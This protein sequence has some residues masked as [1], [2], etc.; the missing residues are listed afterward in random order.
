MRQIE[1][2]NEPGGPLAAR[3]GSLKLWAT[4][5]A[6]I[7]LKKVH[8]KGS[9][10]APITIVE[11]SDL[12]CSHCKQAHDTLSKELFKA[13]KPEQVRLGIEYG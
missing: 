1:L 11:Y 12:Q 7:G 4:R 2:A 6:S 13:Y 9:D 10:K 3:Y 8:A 5:A